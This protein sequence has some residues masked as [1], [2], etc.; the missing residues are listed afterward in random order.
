M[1]V[2]VT[3]FCFIICGRILFF[4][5]KITEGVEVQVPKGWWLLGKDYNRMIQ[6]TVEAAMDLSGI[7]L[8]DGEEVNLIATNSMPRTTYATL[9]IDSTIPPSAT[10][11]EIINI[12]KSELRELSS[13]MD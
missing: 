5:G 1:L 10:L 13:Y 7:G 12:S 2:R 3:G 4:F 8:D 9:R 6:T 11:K